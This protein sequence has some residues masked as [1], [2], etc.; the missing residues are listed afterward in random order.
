[1]LVTFLLTPLVTGLERIRLGRLP[2][3]ISVVLIANVL[4]AG[5]GWVVGQQL[6]DVAIRL[7]DY[8]DNI[9]RKLESLHGS[10]GKGLDRLT[11][12]FQDLGKE[13]S[14][15]APPPT[16]APPPKERAKTAPAS[17]PLPVEVVKPPANA[18]ESVG[19][20]V[21]PMIRPLGKA[22]L[23]L[24]FTIFMLL[25]R[26]DVRNRLIRL[27]SHGRLN[28]ITQAMADAGDR[29]SRYLLMQFI[30]N[31][32]FGGVIALG[33][34]AIGLPSPLLWGAIAGAM[35]FIPYLGPVIGGSLPLVLSLAVFDDWKR[36]LI[37][38]GMFL[39]VEIITANVMEP[40]LY[41]THTGIS[42]LA[43]LVA[44]VFWTVLWGPVGLILSTPLTVC[45]LVIGRNVPQLEF[46]N[47][48]LGDEPVLEQKALFYQ[49]LLAL[50][51]QEARGILNAA[52]KQNALIDLYDEVIIPALAMAEEDRHEGVLDPDRESFVVQ[53]INEF[54]VELADQAPQVPVGLDENGARA[55]CLPAK[56]PADEITAAML[57]QVLEQAG[58]PAIA[59]PVAESP[60]E[61]LRKISRPRDVVFVCALPPFAL[62][63]ARGLSRE[64]RAKFPDTQIVVGLWNYDTGAVDVPER[65]GRAFADT[66]ITTLKQALKKLHETAPSAEPEN[67]PPL[68]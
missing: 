9:H 61:L 43:I 6:L 44:A 3:V 11:T 66:V 18:I 5:G 14:S 37:T 25:N 59:F 46:L 45:L 41:G 16:P 2:A 38:L 62:M 20:L 24:V 51:Q 7:P 68:Q 34:F 33:L 27:L 12:T 40:W 55:L 67:A 60:V 19:D 15:T 10:G 52:L 58:Y 17:H 26:E 35:R 48:L 28:A 53:T 13:L 21:G 47:I 31:M 1:V 50:D 30:V 65:L 4:I 42:P 36:P 23:V 22:V 63:H 64:L 57:A 56:D 49:R 39:L 8:Q 54:L 29:V 32:T